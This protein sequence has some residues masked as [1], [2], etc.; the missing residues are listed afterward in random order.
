[1][2]FKNFNKL[3]N[4]QHP[5]HL[6]DVS[7]WPFMLS[8]ALLNLALSFLCY[9]HYFKNGSYHF[10]LSFSILVFYLFMWFA[11]IILES[12]YEGHHTFKVQ[13]GIR[14]GMCLF[15]IS[16]VCFFLAFFEDFFIVVYLLPL[17]LVLFDLQ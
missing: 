11:D 7:P 5:F 14:L 9:F 6:V 2:T 12:T 8:L 13:Q 17:I 16:E 3:K 15:I 1:M 4:E 10:L